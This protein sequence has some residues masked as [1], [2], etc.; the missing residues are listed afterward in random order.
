MSRINNLFDNLIYSDAE[1]HVGNLRTFKVHKL[2]LCTQSDVFAAMFEHECKEKITNI[3]PINNVDVEVV[4]G[5]L[6][7]LYT[8]MAKN[9]YEIAIRL[10]V[11]ADQ[12]QVKALVNMCM[13]ALVRNI[14]VDNII[15]HLEIFACINKNNY[16]KYPLYLFVK[17]IFK[18]ISKL[19]EWSSFQRDYAEMV[20]DF[21]LFLPMD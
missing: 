12:Y 14:T 11:L 16:F 5:M 7:Y 13:T 8:G 9:I 10:I 6:R 21:M 4:E 3:F 1:V 20:T 2:V 15:E 18:L 19:S 17:T